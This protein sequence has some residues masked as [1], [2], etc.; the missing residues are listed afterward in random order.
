[1]IDLYDCID[2][3]TNL[4]IAVG[5]S[6]LNYFDVETNVEYLVTC[7]ISQA[8]A[9]QRAGRAGRT[10]HGKCYRLYTEESYVNTLKPFTPSE[11]QRIDISWAILQLK[12]LGVSNILRFDY[13]TPPSTDHVIFALEFLYRYY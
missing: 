7:P 1:M 6:R 5:Y 12:A 3:R 10:A 4:M 8:S 11:M 13:L 2:V 9:N